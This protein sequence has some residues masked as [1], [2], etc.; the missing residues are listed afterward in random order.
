MPS[1]TIA[2]PAVLGGLGIG[3]GGLKVAT[4]L[5]L[6]GWEVS[7]ISVAGNGEGTPAARDQTVALSP[8]MRAAVHTPIRLR[9]GWLVNTHYVAFDLM[10][11]MKIRPADFFY[12][13]SQGSLRSLARAR[14]LGATTVLHAAT[15]YVPR[16]KEWVDAE[17][18]SL[19]LRPAAIT[20]A[21]CRRAVAEY[22]MADRVRAQSTMVRDTLVE[23][24]VRS[25]KILLVPP[26]VDLETFVPAK[27]SPGRFT[28]AFVGAFSVRKGFHHLLKA[29]DLIGDADA[30]LI[31][32]GGAVDSWSKQLLDKYRS[33]P[34]VEV[35]TGSPIRTYG[36][37]TVCVIPSVEDGFCYVA[38][39][40][41]AAGLPVIVSDRVGAKDIVE[42]GVSGFITPVGAAEAMAH[43]LGELRDD[44][45]RRRRMGVAA[46]TRAEQHSFAA[47]GRGLSAALLEP[48]AAY[49]T[50]APLG[51]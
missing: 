24:G 50:S 49:A 17:Y 28:V 43:R 16:M 38:L 2:L 37:A 7:T 42:E 11:R 4:S 32:H 14:Q 41:M 40:A 48:A 6:E 45:S 12:G 39:E 9:E 23:G 3:Q 34:R 13:Y 8:I 10:A 36:D 51:A 33:D 35:R 46:R 1:I 47:E 15:S 19:G 20:R 26:A 27:G 18:R 5:A 22:E 25:D 44:S 31:L 21:L 30:R 29:W